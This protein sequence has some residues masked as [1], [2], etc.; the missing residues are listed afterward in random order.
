M[1]K[2]TQH[3][4]SVHI[5]TD[6]YTSTDDRVHVVIGTFFHNEKLCEFWV[7]RSAVLE[8]KHQT[9]SLKWVDPEIIKFRAK[10]DFG[11]TYDHYSSGSYVTKYQIESGT[12]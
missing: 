10:H 12:L 7:T 8:H 3:F 1:K 2:K 5:E 9:G 4:E 6:V 11:I